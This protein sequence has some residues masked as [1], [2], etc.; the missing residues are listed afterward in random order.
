MDDARMRA[1]EK[2]TEAMEARIAAL[3]ELL[4]TPGGVRAQE[5]LKRY[6]KGLT[7]TEAAE[8]I[9]VTRATIYA[10]IA[11][12]R[13][14]ESNSGRVIAQS[15]ADLLYETVE[16]RKRRKRGSRDTLR[17]GADNQ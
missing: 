2:R 11:D 15:V 6:P 17:M 3:E 5:L 16:K 13:L 8:E 12:G 7:K 9:G 4:G 14:K 10:M 1:M